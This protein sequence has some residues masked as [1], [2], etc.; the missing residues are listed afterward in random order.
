M[1]HTHFIAVGNIASPLLEACGSRWR[2]TM[3]RAFKEPDYPPVSDS[4][5][6]ALLAV[7]N[8]ANRILPTEGR[9]NGVLSKTTIIA[10]GDRGRYHTQGY[11]MYCLWQSRRRPVSACRGCRLT[12]GADN[13]YR[14]F[15]CFGSTLLST[16]G[17]SFFF[18]CRFLMSEGPHKIKRDQIETPLHMF[19]VQEN[20]NS[21]TG[22][23]LILHSD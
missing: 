4:R 7:I 22:C 6:L 9:A 12:W 2:A 5:Y 15:D 14:F 20:I 11:S 1:F 18:F 21:Q 19:D 3:A 16:R 13:C 17:V 8:T 10:S 23:S